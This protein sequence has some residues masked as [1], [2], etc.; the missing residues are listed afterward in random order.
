VSTAW[1]GSGRLFALRE[2]VTDARWSLA[3]DWGTLERDGARSPWRTVDGRL[4]GGTVIAGRSG[5]ALFGLRAG[6]EE[7]LV[8][9]RIDDGMTGTLDI[10][11]TRP[12]GQTWAF[13][14]DPQIGP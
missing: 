7:M 3:I 1:L 8:M 5:F 11:A 13:M 2:V 9:L 4:T 6:A 12:R 14:I 10:P